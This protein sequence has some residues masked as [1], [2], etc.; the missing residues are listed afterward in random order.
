MA[1]VT[2]NLQNFEEL[3]GT[4]SVFDWNRSSTKNPDAPD[5][6]SIASFN[7][8]S[9]KH[10]YVHQQTSKVVR[11]LWAT[12]RLNFEHEIFACPIERRTSTRWI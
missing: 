9:R 2:K 5:S 12:F 11:R 6:N 3:Q 4:L 8:K 1:V 7:Y 10:L